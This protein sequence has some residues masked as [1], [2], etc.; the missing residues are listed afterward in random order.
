MVKTEYL[1]SR[2][3]RRGVIHEMIYYAVAYMKDGQIHLKP[4]KTK[5]EAE[6][7]LELLKASKWGPQIDL[8]KVVKK[9]TSKEWFKSVNG[10]WI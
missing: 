9:D 10:Y 1:L 5:E 7:N 2:W 3:Y 6:H 4:F 8:T